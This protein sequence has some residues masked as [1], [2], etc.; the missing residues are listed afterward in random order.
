MNSKI[1]P[2]GLSGSEL[3][4]Q[5]TITS[6]GVI[7]RQITMLKKLL[8]VIHYYYQMGNVLARCFGKFSYSQFSQAKLGQIDNT[9]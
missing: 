3:E 1:G 4:K 2:G 9:F 7:Y 6:P 8:F 5:Q